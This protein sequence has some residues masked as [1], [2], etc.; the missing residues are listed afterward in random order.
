[1]CV[2]EKPPRSSLQKVKEA[3]IE[4]YEWIP[5]GLSGT[6]VTKNHCL[7]VLSVRSFLVL[8]EH[9]RRDFKRVIMEPLFQLEGVYCFHV[10]YSPVR[11]SPMQYLF[12]LREGSSVL[13]V[14]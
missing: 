7:L 2:E 8:A 5:A 4:G 9:R 6:Q 14:D 1:M 12:S 13:Q 11:T 10:M 3:H